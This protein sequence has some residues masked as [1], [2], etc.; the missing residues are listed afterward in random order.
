MNPSAKP[1]TAPIRACRNGWNVYILPSA[2]RK[3]VKA[4][5]TVQPTMF[6][7]LAI[8]PALGYLSSESRTATGTPFS[9]TA[10]SRAVLSFTASA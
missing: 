7:P 3:T 4:I 6:D 8:H 9:G 10:Y 2:M 1:I 5:P